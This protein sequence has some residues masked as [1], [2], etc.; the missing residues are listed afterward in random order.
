ML[1]EM[2]DLILAFR[3]APNPSNVPGGTTGSQMCQ[4]K[5]FHFYCVLM[6]SLTSTS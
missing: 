4:Q 1:F 6:K 2:Q 5:Y 3:E